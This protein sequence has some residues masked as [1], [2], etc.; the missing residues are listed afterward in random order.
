MEQFRPGQ[1]ILFQS[2]RRCVV[3][4][5]RDRPVLD[6]L[7]VHK[8][9]W[10]HARAMSVLPLKADIRQREWHVRYVPQADIGFRLHLGGKEG[11]S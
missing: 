5:A 4:V 11:F 7:R 9:K 6:P 1:A 8:R 10:Y 2:R 3:G